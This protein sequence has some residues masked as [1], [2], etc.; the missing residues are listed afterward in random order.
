MDKLSTYRTTVAPAADGGTV[1]TY[2]STPIVHIHPDRSVTL[3]SGGYQTVTTKRKM[4][5]A[6]RQFGLG[7]VVFQC[8][9]EWFVALRRDDAFDWDNPVNFTDG[10]T[11][12]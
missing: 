1:V 8:D 12:R 11:V 7:Y 4:N 9:F 6:A 10:M 2:V 3:R 5:Q